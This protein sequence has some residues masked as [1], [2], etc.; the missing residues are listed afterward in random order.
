MKRKDGQ[1]TSVSKQTENRVF[2]KKTGLEAENPM[3]R[4]PDSA[5]PSLEEIHAE[6]ASSGFSRCPIFQFAP[7]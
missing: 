7:D 6:S 5:N 4:T 1:K 2:L 3:N